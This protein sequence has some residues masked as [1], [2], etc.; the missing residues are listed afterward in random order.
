MSKTFV[1][2]F[3]ICENSHLI[4][5][6]GQIPFFFHRLYGYK[7]TVVTHRLS[8]NYSHLDEE[9]KGINIHFLKDLG[10]Y[11]F[12]QKGII[13]YLLKESK[14]I[15]ILNIYH[16]THQSFLYGL[17][18]KLK[19]PNGF[20]FHKL[21]AYNEQFSKNST[22]NYS[23]N[24]IKNLILKQ[25]ERYYLSKCDLFTIEN[26]TGLQLF[27]EKYPKAKGKTI[28]LPNGVNDLYLSKHFSSTKKFHEKENIILTTGRIGLQ[29]KNHEMLLRAISDTRFANLNWKVYFIGPTKVSF[30]QYFEEM[31]GRFPHLKH[32]V[33]FTGE[34]NDRKMVYQWYN[35]S[36]LF[37]TTSPFESFG[38]SL[39]EAQYFG[40]YLIGT[41]GVS[42]FNDITN[43]QKYGHAVKV[44][45][46]QFLTSKLLELMTDDK[47]MSEACPKISEY[48]KSHFVWSGIVQKLHQEIDKRTGNQNP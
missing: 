48:C 26:S 5:D 13:R 19:N 34:I 43:N 22:I 32:I 8:E 18:Y 36:K 1:T 7:S 28:Y 42:S 10:N 3:P 37:V 44:N 12:A 46:D 31:C 40:N 6:I 38:I 21:D 30:V 41:D 24:K 27:T 4:K 16:F 39:I 11:F 14:K 25:L 29:V 9:V 2:L 33:H 20:V 45:D 15:D 23:K 17:I 35:R 47:K